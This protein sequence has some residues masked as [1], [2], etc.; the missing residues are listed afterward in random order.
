MSSTTTSSSNV[1]SP[2]TD[3][4]FNNNN[5][6]KSILQTPSIPFW[7][8]NPNILLQ[9]T[10]ELFPVENMTYNQSLNAITRLVILITI[11]MFFVFRKW[12]LVFISLVTL[13]SIWALQQYHT[14]K[15]EK[16]GKKV[17]FKSG[18]D[19]SG[20]GEE[21]DSNSTLT[22]GF[23]SK[24]K[25]PAKELM[26]EVNTDIF[27][28]PSSTNPF[29]NTLMTDYDYNPHKKPAPPSFN[30]NVNDDILN[31]AKKNVIDCNPGQPDIADKLFRDLGDQLVF[32]QSMRPFYSTASTTIPNDQTSFAEFC[33]GSMISC[34]EG[35]KFA[36]ARNLSRHTN[37]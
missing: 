34:K 13:G 4:S 17:S 7:G 23:V 33:Y 24:Y 31:Q 22:E 26:G 21:D 6:K 20:S 32:E 36:C 35:N 30:V 5:Q 8:D 3:I 19:K 18:S 37:I 11:I 27:Q 28:K 12:T 14:G 1:Y 15:F 9:N 25:N 16:K 10:S 29:S 2:V